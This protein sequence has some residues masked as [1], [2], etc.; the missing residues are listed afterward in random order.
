[1]P[2][3]KILQ[4]GRFA[5]WPLERTGVVGFGRRGVFRGA[6]LLENGTRRRLRRGETALGVFGQV[7][8]DLRPRQAEPVR[9][10]ASQ[11]HGVGI[12]RRLLDQEAE[13]ELPRQIFVKFTNQVSAE[14]GLRRL[15][16][17]GIAIEIAEVDAVDE[18]HRRGV[19]V[20][21]REIPSFISDFDPERAAFTAKL[22]VPTDLNAGRRQWSA[23]APYR[24]RR[25]RP[26]QIERMIHQ[27]LANRPLAVLAVGDAGGG[28]SLVI[29]H[30]EQPW[31][32][33]G[34]AGEDKD[35]S[36]YA[37]AFRLRPILLVVADVVD[38]A[39]TAVL[40]EDDLRGDGLVHHVD[41]P[42]PHRVCQRHAR[43]I[44][45]LD[46]TD[47]NAVGVAGTDATVL[48]GL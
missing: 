34:V 25:Q 38:A 9:D 28:A 36:G 21:G 11:R 33:D 19:G 2:G 47:R 4:A 3:A 41:P 31:R 43:I 18:I 12:V 29:R 22:A 46:R 6:H 44:F 27:V 40:V 39:D 5:R 14:Q 23:I 15:I 24:V 10:T 8:I 37:A 20:A 26:G 16:A 35:F 30:Q 48:I 42:G 32:L 17:L 1:M 45:G 13:A 7:I